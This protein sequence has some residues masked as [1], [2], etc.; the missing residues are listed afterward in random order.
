MRGCPGSGKTHTAQHLITITVKKPFSDHIFS[1]DD[2]FDRD[3]KNGY[4]FIPEHLPKAHDWNLK[5]VQSVTDKGISP[6]IVDNTNSE[7][8]EMAPY[9]KLAVANG[10]V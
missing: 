4:L 2:Y 10:Y 8:W 7:P 6:I 9:M 1:T 3:K 5:R